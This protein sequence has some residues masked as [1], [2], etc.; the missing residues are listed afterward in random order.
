MAVPSIN[1]TKKPG[2]TTNANNYLSLTN[3]PTPGLTSQSSKPVAGVLPAS[4]TPRVGVSSPAAL[5]V[6]GLIPPP[7]TGGVP[8]SNITNFTPQ[9]PVPSVASTSNPNYNAQVAP[10][11]NAPQGTQLPQPQVAQPPVVTPVAGTALA[12]SGVKGLYAN[13]AA[14][15]SNLGSGVNPISQQSYEASLKTMEDI[16]NLKLQ[17]AGETAQAYNNPIAGN[18]GEGRGQILQKE[19]N[20]KIQALVDLYGQQAG[21]VGAGTTQQS[22]QG[23]ILNSAADLAKP[24]QNF[25]FVFDPTTGT[26][27]TPGV[28]GGAQGATGTQ[29][30]TYNPQQDAQT[31]AQQVINHEINYEDAL[32]GIGYAGT[33]AEGM[34]Q[35]AILRGGGNLNELKAQGGVQSAQTTQKEQYTSALQQA[36]N[37]GTQLTD[38]ITSSG[39]Q[40]S[41]V[42]KVNQLLQLIAQNTSD[43]R[44]QAL[45]SYITDIAATYAQV[46]TPDGGSPT[47]YART[48]ASS[49]ISSAASGQSIITQLKVLDEQ[50]KAK[51]KGISTVT[52][53]S[54]SQGPVSAGGYQFKQDANGNWVPA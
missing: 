3:T 8:T 29:G 13:T 20:D 12:P 6:A 50:A 37:L 52:P 18:F 16:K 24:Q 48:L 5:G 4:T 32:K 9:A 51:I 33:T 1:L 39:I 42:N 27:T 15:L 17:A 35:Q 28:S 53:K 26:Y 44:Y 46:L 22:A 11:A 21:L 34:L 31:L 41:E 49:L 38:L 36:Q 43:P 2:S 7:Q 10:F 23:N 40:P 25:P 19:Y 54:S 30:L 14:S 47:D 45:A